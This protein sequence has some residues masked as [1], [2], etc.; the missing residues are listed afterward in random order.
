MTLRIKSFHLVMI[1]AAFWKHPNYRNHCFPS[2]PPFLLWSCTSVLPWTSHRLLN[3]FS[4]LAGKM[5][6]QHRWSGRS[7]WRQG[8]QERA[9]ISGSGGWGRQLSPRPLPKISPVPGSVSLSTAISIFSRYFNFLLYLNTCW[10]PFPQVQW[11]KVGIFKR[12]I[13]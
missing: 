12:N 2:P 5:L 9:E 11:D 10:I 6:L 8:Q 7:P 4:S 1:V 13:Y 3:V